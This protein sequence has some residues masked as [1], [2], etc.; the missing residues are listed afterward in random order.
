MEGIRCIP[1]LSGFDILW[2][3]T[4]DGQLELSYLDRSNK[5]KSKLV[6][7]RA[8]PEEGDEGAKAWCDAAMNVAYKGVE[9][10]LNGPNGKLKSSVV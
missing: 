8:K 10:P 6:H 4:S 9:S 1:S 7:F 2:V 5:G 3:E